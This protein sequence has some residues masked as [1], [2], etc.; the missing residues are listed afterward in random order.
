MNDIAKESTS[1][2][3]I[4][5]I[6]SEKLS[7]NDAATIIGIKPIYASMIKTP[8][9]WHKCPTAA[10]ESVKTWVNSGETLRNYAK[11]NNIDINTK[12]QIRMN[13]SEVI[14]KPTEVT[15]KI[16]PKPVEV[17]IKH[18]ETNTESQKVIIDIEIN[19]TIN[20]KKLVL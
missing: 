5:A 8:K 2:R 15:E 6:E 9:S 18:N 20:G 14:E 13:H 12:P 11:K 17:E 7:T 19:I 3:L 4:K 10:F 1:N 16:K